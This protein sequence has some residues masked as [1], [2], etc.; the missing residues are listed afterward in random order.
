VGGGRRFLAR[1]ETPDFGA[2]DEWHS[3]WPGVR[4]RDF[5][6]VENVLAMTRAGQGRDMV[7]THWTALSR[8]EVATCQ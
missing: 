6:E 5:V 8:C 1:W 7:A 2:F 3:D 4:E